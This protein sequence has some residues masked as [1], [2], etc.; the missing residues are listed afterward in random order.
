MLFQDREQLIQLSKSELRLTIDKR[1]KLSK[2]DAA[3]RRAIKAVSE[4][5]EVEER[6]LNPDL[7]EMAQSGAVIRDRYR[8]TLELLACREE[9]IELARTIRETHSGDEAV[10]SVRLSRVHE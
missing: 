3:T 7:P 1:I 4:S 10:E 5:Q 2:E 8:I 6:E 9:A